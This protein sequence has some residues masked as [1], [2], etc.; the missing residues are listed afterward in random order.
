MTKQAVNL[1]LDSALL[2]D[3]RAAGLNLSAE[4][5]L[6][7]TEKLRDARKLAWL[8]HNRAAIDAYNERIEKHG[9]FNADLLNF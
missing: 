3:A 8:E 5:E 7:L 2:S 4:L 9:P 1:S 6:C